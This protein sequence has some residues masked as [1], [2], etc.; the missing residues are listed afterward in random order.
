MYVITYDNMGNIHASRGE[1]FIGGEILSDR[2]TPH[3]SWHPSGVAPNKLLSLGPIWLIN[4]ENWVDIYIEVYLYR[5]CDLNVRTNFFRSKILSILIHRIMLNLQYLNAN[6]WI[7]LNTFNKFARHCSKVY[8]IW[9]AIV[10]FNLRL[11]TCFTFGE[12]DR[13]NGI[14]I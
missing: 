11:E 7:F 12:T 8:I 10:Y 1:K 14:E 13:W 4:M 9:N 6:I 2:N 5:E 3:Y